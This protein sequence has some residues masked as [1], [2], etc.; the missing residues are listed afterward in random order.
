MSYDYQ[1]LSKMKMSKL[2][3]MTEPTLRDPRMS[4]LHLEDERTFIFSLS[5][6]VTAKC[7]P[8]SCQAAMRDDSIM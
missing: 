5:H 1:K 2:F 6:P 3:A 4:P 7:L 8:C